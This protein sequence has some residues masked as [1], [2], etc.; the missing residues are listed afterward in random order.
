MYVKNESQQ[1]I[2]KLRFDLA[3][4]FCLLG[5]AKAGRPGNP[6]PDVCYYLGDRYWWLAAEYERRGDKSKAKRL[7]DKAE[8]YLRASGWWHGGPPP[9]GAMALPVPKRPTFAAAIGWRSRR[10][11]PDD[12]A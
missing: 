7:R 11:P 12:A 2:Y 3:V 6:N 8:N 9:S 10:D 5:I 1:S 4:A